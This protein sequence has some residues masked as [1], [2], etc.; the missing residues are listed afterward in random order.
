[1]WRRTAFRNELGISNALTALISIPGA[2]LAAAPGAKGLAPARPF[3]LGSNPHCQLFADNRAQ[4]PLV[5]ALSENFRGKQQY[6]KQQRHAK[7]T[8]DPVPVGRGHIA[9]CAPRSSK[10]G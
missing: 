8:H 9:A 6:K 5:L 10:S 3:D 1:M 7:K 4:K 2:A